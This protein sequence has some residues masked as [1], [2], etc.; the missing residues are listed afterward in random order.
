MLG[1]LEVPY[2]VES[3]VRLG[4]T[5]IGHALLQLLRY[6]WGDA[7]RRELFGFLRSPYSGL[8][9]SSVDYVEG[10]LRGRAIHTPARVEEEAEK[11]REAP[12][13][14]LAELRA[15]EDPVEAVRDQLRAM[16]RA[17]YGTDAPPA[18][19]VSRLDLRA[20]GHVLQLL[21][22]LARLDA[23]ARRGDRRARAL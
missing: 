17:A 9:R 23:S 21:T 5:P 6:A 15:A 3:R 12:I 1:S 7:G 19:E 18:G 14:A 8:A 4:T 16:L 11:L 10:R 13:P 2:A 22:E 20:Y